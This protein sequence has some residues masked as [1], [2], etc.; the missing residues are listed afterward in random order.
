MSCVFPRAVAYGRQGTFAA[1]LALVRRTRCSTR[2]QSLRNQHTPH[3][4][5]ILSV[6]DWPGPRASPS[7]SAVCR[8]ALRPCVR[9]R[10][11]AMPAKN[12]IE[13]GEIAKPAFIGDGGEHVSG[14]G[15]IAQSPQGQGEAP[16]SDKVGE[17]R[18]LSR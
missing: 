16:A 15:G 9:G 12:A 3:T 17:R 18:L 7:V 10:H 6:V 8:H 1:M 2:R 13:I 11:A 14:A 4:A 5:V